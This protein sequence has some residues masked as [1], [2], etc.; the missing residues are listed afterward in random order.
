MIKKDIKDRI[1]IYD[2]TLS[3]SE[4]KP[5]FPKTML[6][7]VSNICNHTCA[8]CANSKSDRKKGFVDKEFA[9][10]IISEAYKPW[11]AG[12]WLLCDGRTVGGSES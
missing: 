7:E 3:C 11:N 4:L 9:K 1:E 6:L 5:P 8:F 2:Q 10:R 12:N